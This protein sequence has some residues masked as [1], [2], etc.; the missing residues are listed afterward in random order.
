MTSYEIVSFVPPPGFFS[1]KLKT[2]LGLSIPCSWVISFT[3]WLD[4]LFGL[5]NA[6]NGVAIS[7]GCIVNTP[8]GFIKMPWRGAKCSVVP[9]QVFFSIRIV[10]GSKEGMCLKRRR[11]KDNNRHANALQEEAAQNCA[12]TERRPKT[13]GSCVVIR[14]SMKG[15]AKRDG[16]TFCWHN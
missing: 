13:L 5:I 4:P 10:S 11:Q 15:E 3:P 9:N 7:G 14:S 8:G 1:S 6:T 2:C 16:R 12:G